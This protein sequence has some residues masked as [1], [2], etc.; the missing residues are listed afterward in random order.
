MALHATHLRAH[1]CAAKAYHAAAPAAAT[2]IAAKRH[3]T[4]APAAVASSCLAAKALDATLQPEAG[5]IP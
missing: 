3:H 2:R 1:V 4:A 5:A